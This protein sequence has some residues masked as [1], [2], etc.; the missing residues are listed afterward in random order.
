MSASPS[1]P[2]RSSTHCFALPAPSR[3][4]IAAVARATSQSSGSGFS[5]LPC[6]KCTVSVKLPCVVSSVTRALARRVTLVESPEM[7]ARFPASR[8]ARVTLETT[9][10][11]FTETVHFPHGS[12]ENPLPDDWL[13]ARATAA[14]EERLG[15]GSAKQCVEDLLGL[16]G[17]ADIGAL[18]RRLSAPHSPYRSPSPPEGERAG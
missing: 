14:I 3:S 9:H 2:S 7:E 12:T 6:G 5:V 11:S 8:S 10:G 17:L 16:D 15:A 13:V 18:A 1:S 4:S